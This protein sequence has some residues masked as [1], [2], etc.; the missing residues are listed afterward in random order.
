MATFQCKE[1]MV[2]RTQ[3]LDIQLDSKVSPVWF[4]FISSNVSVV[5]ETGYNLQ[6]SL[7]GT[8]PFPRTIY[9]H[10]Y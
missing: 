2:S 8:R 1:V 9:L 6:L 5:T 4:S 10:Y 7:P 3:R